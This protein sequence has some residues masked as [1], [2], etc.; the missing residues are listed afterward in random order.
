MSTM[1]HRRLEVIVLYSYSILRL[2]DVCVFSVHSDLECYN[3]E[4]T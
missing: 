1:V 2:P 4:S 3:T